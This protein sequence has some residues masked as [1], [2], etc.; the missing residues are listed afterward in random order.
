MPG[1]NAAPTQASSAARVRPS[2]VTLGGGGGGAP[3]Q[4]STYV[5]SFHFLRSAYCDLVITWCAPLLSS[6]RRGISAIPAAVGAFGS[7][8]RAKIDCRCAAVAPENEPAKLAW[9]CAA[10]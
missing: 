10:I 4:S 3:G 2:G 8:T 5:P 9:P 6:K 1:K 7:R